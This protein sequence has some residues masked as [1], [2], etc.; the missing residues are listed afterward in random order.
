MMYVVKPSRMT[1]LRSGDYGVMDL[2]IVSNVEDR[3][4]LSDALFAGS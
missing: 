4:V 2:E 3:F 1:P